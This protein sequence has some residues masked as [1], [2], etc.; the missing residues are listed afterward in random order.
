MTYKHPWVALLGWFPP[1]YL[2]GIVRHWDKPWCSS[3]TGWIPNPVSFPVFWWP[4]KLYQR[5]KY[6]QGYR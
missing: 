4:T 2:F 3:D 6:E 1:V 5:R